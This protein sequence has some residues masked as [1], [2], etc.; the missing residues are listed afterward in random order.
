MGNAASIFS[1]IEKY[2][3]TNVK[4][5]DVTKNLELIFSISTFNFVEMEYPAT[6]QGGGKYA[7]STGAAI[8]NISKYAAH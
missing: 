5:D 4:L 6:P 7:P 3:S 8:S 2:I 1:N